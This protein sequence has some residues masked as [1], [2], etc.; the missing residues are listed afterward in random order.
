MYSQFLTTVI[1]LRIAPILMALLP[2]HVTWG[3][4]GMAY[5]AVVSPSLLHSDKAE[6]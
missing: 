4:A 3:I 2:A 5:Y 6:F 1:F